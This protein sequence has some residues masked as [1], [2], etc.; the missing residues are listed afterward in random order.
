[1]KVNTKLFQLK[2]LSFVIDEKTPFMGV[3]SSIILSIRYNYVIL[4][5]KGMIP[6]VTYD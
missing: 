1:M 6:M 4:K 5:L 3:F 2:C